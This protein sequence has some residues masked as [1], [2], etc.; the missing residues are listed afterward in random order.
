M[1]E[2]QP[3]IMRKVW[4]LFCYYLPFLRSDKAI[5][6]TQGVVFNKVCLNDNF[7][8]SKIEIN[9]SGLIIMP[10]QTVHQRNETLVSNQGFELEN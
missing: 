8:V 9:T 10:D 3:L 6:L 7:W 1:A 2:T 4:S 5:L